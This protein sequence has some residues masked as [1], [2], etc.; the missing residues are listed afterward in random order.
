MD[1]QVGGRADILFGPGRC[2]APGHAVL[3]GGAA[4]TRS[5]GTERQP[6]ALPQRRRFARDR[7]R[8]DAVPDQWRAACEQAEESGR[9]RE[10]GHCDGQGVGGRVPRRPDFAGGV[11]C[12]GGPDLLVT[13][14]HLWSAF[15]GSPI[16]CHTVADCSSRV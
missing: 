13:S 3:G 4:H 10:G 15:S 8:Q 16:Q 14:T 12:K 11:L 6:P 9:G 7:R 5:D 1:L 2:R